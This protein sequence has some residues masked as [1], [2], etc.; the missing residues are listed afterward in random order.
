MILLLPA[1]IKSILMKN[2]KNNGGK[3]CQYNWNLIN[4]YL[5]TVISN[6]SVKRLNNYITFRDFKNNI[7]NNICCEDMICKYNIAPALIT[8]LSKYSQ[9]EITLS[10]N[11]FLDCYNKGMSLKEISDK[12]NIKRNNIRFLRQLYNIKRKGAAFIYRKRTEVCLSQRQKDILYGSMMGDASSK[13]IHYNSSVCFCHGNKQKEYLFWKCNEFKNIVSNIYPKFCFRKE[14]RPEYSGSSGSWIFQTCA[15]TDV[16]ICLNKF[17]KNGK[18]KICKDVLCN[19]S[20]LSL[21]VWFM[22]DGYSIKSKKNKISNFAFCTD[23]FSKEDCEDI[24]EWFEKKY[25]IKSYI[26]RRGVNKNNIETYR[27]IIRSS[28]VNLFLSLI[29]SYIIPSM[30]YKIKKNY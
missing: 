24:V 17:Y 15:N 26:R 11:E 25:K 19:L 3:K 12:Y 20:D 4:P 16:E 5:D 10:E 23:S 9:G 13:D 30:R 7:I 27:V 1:F 6:G 2:K 18:K 28:S 21:A 22:D 8:F 14:I 29:S